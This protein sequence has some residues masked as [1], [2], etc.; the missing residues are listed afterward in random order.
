V[1]CAA[2]A[3]LLVRAPMM[4]KTALL[5]AVV[6]T[7]CGGGGGDGGDDEPMH[8]PD[9]TWTVFV[10]GHGDH[11]LS[12]SLQVDIEE[13]KAATLRQNVT[14]VVLADYD[15]SQGAEHPT[16]AH[17]MKIANG[18]VENIETA[19]E[20]DLD[21]PA[22]LTSSIERAFKLVPAD[23]HALV[24]WNHGGAWE[25]GFGGDTRDGATHKPGM[26]MPAA[27]AAVRAGL[28]KAG[29]EYLDVLAF[30][31]CL[32]GGMES[33]AEFVG[34]AD[35]Y[36]GNGELDYGDGLDYKA[37]LTYLS[38]KPDTTYAALAM[39][40]SAAYKTHHSAQLI[41]RLLHAHV[42]LRL[43]EMPEV[44][45]RAKAL[46]EAIDS[47]EAALAVGRAMFAA[48]PNYL[49]SQFTPEGSGNP[50]LHDIGQVADVL[51]GAGGDIGAAANALADSLDGLVLASSLGELRKDAQVGL[52]VELTKPFDAANKLGDYRTKAAAWIRGTAWD[53]MI[54]GVAGFA[55]EQ[56]PAVQGQVVASDTVRFQTA[57]TDIADASFE[58]AEV[59]NGVEYGYGFVTAGAIT[60][61]TALDMTWGGEVGAMQ[62]ANGLEAV[63]AEPWA[64]A[65]AGDGSPQFKMMFVPGVLQAGGEEA[66][67]MLLFDPMTGQAPVFAIFDPMSQNWATRTTAELAEAG[68][69]LT[70]RPIVPTYDQAGNANIVRLGAINVTAAPLAVGLATMN[71]GT[72]RLN[73]FA[74]D[75]WGNEALYPYDLTVG[76]GSLTRTVVS[77]RPARRVAWLDR[78]I[79]AER[80]GNVT[81]ALSARQP[82]ANRATLVPRA[83]GGMIRLR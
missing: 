67:V 43:D 54:E 1:L 80:A 36:V 52:N 68:Q 34:I 5:A 76:G 79:A 62:T 57:D 65:Y 66:L 46:V 42:A 31:T 58:L 8:E 73:L 81:V 39:A 75:L 19:P 11:N 48:A 60:P 33:A 2:L 15:A 25:G 16:G 82:A 14:V 78:V 30:D 35:V 12:P 70:F 23:R 13:M 7:G 59:V 83:R 74:K 44:M 63:Y 27:A 9:A 41:D 71:P 72:Y 3:A 61:N 40:D 29:V 53:K 50:G 38:D 6:A 56:A 26:M 32:L 37:L 49:N 51:A 45:T 22:V 55:D 77:S 20:A 21:D 4:M 18:T 47:Q 24:M 28:E 17:W 69:G 10:Y 64:L